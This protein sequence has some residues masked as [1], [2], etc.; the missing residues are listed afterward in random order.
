M[1]WSRNVFS[2]NVETVSYDPETQEM[3][4]TWTK[5]KNRVSVYEGV[6]E[7]VADEASRAF[8]VGQFLNAEI[9]P[10]YPHRY[11]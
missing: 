9:K 3:T 1:S 6:P 5:G 10:R 8:S 11:K 4:V 2:S 7:Q